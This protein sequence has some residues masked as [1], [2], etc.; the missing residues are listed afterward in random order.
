MFFVMSSASSVFADYYP[1]ISISGIHVAGNTAL[2]YTTQDVSTN[3]CSY[4]GAK[5]KFEHS[6]PA[7]KNMFNLI[8]L[9]KTTGTPISV[10]FTPSEVPQHDETG[11]CVISNLAVMNAVRN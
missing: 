11:N 7:G 8:L 6:T 2:I 1:A 10:W 9:A 3:T 5:F 4:Y